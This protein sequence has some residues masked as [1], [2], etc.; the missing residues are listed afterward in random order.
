MTSKRQQE[1]IHQ[2]LTTKIEE[3]T[4]ADMPAETKISLEEAESFIFP[5]M[6]KYKKT[7]RFA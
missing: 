7:S 5:I 2:R 1:A 4:S 6:G 3:G